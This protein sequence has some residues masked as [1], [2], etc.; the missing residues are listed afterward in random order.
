MI[1]LKA[2]TGAGSILQL[3]A[4]PFGGASLWVGED[5][6]QMAG[7]RIEIQATS[8]VRI[9]R[10]S[11]APTIGTNNSRFGCLYCD[12]S[13]GNSDCK[14]YFHNGSTWKEVTLS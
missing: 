8:G 7:D 1:E 13:G 6:F 3:A 14:L 4:N 2:Q 11:S 5:I 9:P 12:T 10:F